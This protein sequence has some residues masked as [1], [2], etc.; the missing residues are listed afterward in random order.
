[1]TLHSER[2]T[3][4]KLELPVHVHVEL[5]S[6]VRSKRGDA[7][8][9]AEFLELFASVVVSSPEL[10]AQLVTMSPFVMPQRYGEEFQ[11]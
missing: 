10:R 4:V 5:E 6:W 11:G 9:A 7:M 1:M 8:T 3:Q 2:T